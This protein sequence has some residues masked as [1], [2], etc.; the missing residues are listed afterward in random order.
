MPPKRFVVLLGI[1]ACHTTLI[2][3]GDRLPEIM[4]QVIAGTVYLPLWSLQAVGLPV[5]GRA[6]SGGWP[7]PSVLGWALVAAIWTA[8]WTILVSATAKLRT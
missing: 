6:E 3:L 2:A 7:G 5:F 8:L 1:L 4:A